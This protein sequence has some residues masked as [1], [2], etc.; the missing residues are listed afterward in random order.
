[1]YAVR[2]RNVFRLEDLKTTTWD[3]CKWEANITLGPNALNEKSDRP[4]M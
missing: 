3:I 2:L 4:S 1:M